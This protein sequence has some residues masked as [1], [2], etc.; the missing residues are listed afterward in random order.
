[1]R[2]FQIFV[3]IAIIF[4]LPL[5]NI[6]CQSTSAGGDVVE[7]EV[8]RLEVFEVP[9]VST[10]IVEVTRL[11]PI[12]QE[13]SVEVTRIVDR[14]IIQSPGLPGTAENPFLLVFLPGSIEQIVDVR[15]GFLVDYLEANT[16]YR[17]DIVIPENRDEGISL[18]CNNPQRTIGILLTEDYIRAREACDVQL[19]LTATRFDVPYSLGML[20]AQTDQVIN[21]IEDVAYKRVGVP[22]EADLTIYKSFE[23]QIEELSLLGVEYVE[24]DTSSSVL[25]A[26]LN[27]EIDIA[28]AEYYPP[29]MPRNERVWEFGADQP[30]IWRQLGIEPARDPIGFVEVAGGPEFGGYRI[31]DSRSAIF[32]DFPEIFNETKI[33]TLSDPI[34]NEAIV[35]G[36]A[37]PLKAAVEVTTAINAFANSEACSQS[38]CASDFYQWTGLV[39]QPDSYYDIIVGLGESEQE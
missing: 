8:T 1:M 5:L 37:F 32:D 6:A 30:E 12:E 21:V 28:A 22:S 38:L 26:L 33:V 15:G 39:A 20:V 23:A 35:L 9:V 14:E 36:F 29:I 25:I 11:V 16:G 34:P 24:Y 2:K 10:Q 19:Q 13:V 18:V 27:G 17:F 31:R 3:F 7:V 4:T